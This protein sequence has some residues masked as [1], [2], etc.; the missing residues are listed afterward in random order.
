MSKNQMHLS[1]MWDK[2]DIRIAFCYLGKFPPG[3]GRA[4]FLRTIGCERKKPFQAEH[5][6]CLGIN[7]GHVCPRP[8]SCC[9]LVMCISTTMRTHR[10]ETSRNEVR[11]GQTDIDREKDRPIDRPIER[12]Q[13]DRKQERDRERE[14]GEREREERG[15][16]RE[17]RGERERDRE[18][19]RQTDRETERQRGASW[20]RRDVD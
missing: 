4:R 16:R 12:P 2:G 19:D 14:R 18:T 8:F 20:A 9:R 11:C 3:P 15:E 17:E 5:C 13:V 7:R 1:S 10:H 6:N